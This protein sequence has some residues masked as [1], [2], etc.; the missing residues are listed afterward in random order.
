MVLVIVLKPKRE[1]QA[2]YEHP[3]QRHLDNPAIKHMCY[4]F[5]NAEIGQPEEGAPF[6]SR[7]SGSDSMLAE[8]LLIFVLP[9]P[10]HDILESSGASQV[11]DI[12][13]LSQERFSLLKDN[14][15][16]SQS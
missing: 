1:S 7:H 13:L 15:W 10:P 8:V 6:S 2:S 12:D 4:T 16:A 9:S 14:F 5:L 3:L 11:E